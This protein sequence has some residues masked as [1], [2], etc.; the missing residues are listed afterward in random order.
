MEED[1]KTPVT[2]NLSPEVIRFFKA[3]SQK[4]QTK[5]NDVLVAFVETYQKVHH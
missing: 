2:I 1:K 4:Y 3:H 5:I